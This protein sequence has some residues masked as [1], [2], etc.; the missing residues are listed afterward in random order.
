MLR[1]KAEVRLYQDSELKLGKPGVKAGVGGSQDS[2]P[3]SNEKVKG[4]KKGQKQ[5]HKSLPGQYTTS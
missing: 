5:A 1:V 4:L 3:V 2:K